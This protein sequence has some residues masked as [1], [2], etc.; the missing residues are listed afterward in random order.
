MAA[1]L[2][3]EYGLACSTAGGTH[4]ALHDAGAGFCIVNDLA[5]TTEVL[6]RTRPGIETVLIVDLDVH[7]GDGEYSFSAMFCPVHA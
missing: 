7:Q 1:D 4:H 2:A 6:L 3:L 5:I